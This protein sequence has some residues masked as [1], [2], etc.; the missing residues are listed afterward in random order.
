MAAGPAEKLKTRIVKSWKRARKTKYRAKIGEGGGWKA[1]TVKRV[2]QIRRRGF[3]GA[4][5]PKRTIPTSFVTTNPPAFHAKKE[6][7]R[8]R[9]CANSHYRI[10]IANPPNPARPT[11][12]LA[13]LSSSGS[14]GVSAAFRP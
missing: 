4:N 10:V 6:N 14:R 9:A 11:T 5:R 2:K 1:A 8:L 7:G 13:R 3:V 12:Y